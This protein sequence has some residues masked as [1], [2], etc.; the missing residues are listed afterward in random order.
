MAYAR[1]G[2]VRKARMRGMGSAFTDGAAFGMGR[3][4]YGT[5]VA[6]VRGGFVRKAHMRGMGSTFTDEAAFGMGRRGYGTS[7]ACAC[8]GFVWE[9]RLMGAARLRMVN[10]AFSVCLICLRITNDIFGI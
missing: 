8:G 5:S 2:F 9:M 3:R 6:Y 1:G 10:G 4:G 7:A